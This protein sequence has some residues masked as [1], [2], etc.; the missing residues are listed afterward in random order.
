LAAIACAPGGSRTPDARLRTAALYPL[1][2]GRE[3]R[4]KG[5]LPAVNTQTVNGRQKIWG[6]VGLL[7]YLV[8]GAFPYLTSGLMVPGP[9]LYILWG[10]WLVGAGLAWRT[11][12]RRPAMVLVFAPVAVAVW[13]VFVTAGEQLFG[14]TA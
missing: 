3:C 1:S 12:Q 14:W 5:S 11:F 8:V 9:W 7:A 4:L 13:F 10:I 6:I 2:Y